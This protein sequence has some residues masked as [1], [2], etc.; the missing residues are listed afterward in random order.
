MINR[1]CTQVPVVAAEATPSLGEYRGFLAACVMSVAIA[2]TGCILWSRGAD[3][4]EAGTSGAL[5][6]SPSHALGDRGALHAVLS[7]HEW[8]AG[9]PVRARI[10]APR[11]RIW[12][13]TLDHVHV[14]DMRSLA[15]VGRFEL[16]SGSM[17]AFICPPDLVLNESGVAFVSNN[18]QPTLLEIDLATKSI[19]E[20]RLATVSSKQ[21]EIGFG[22]LLFGPDGTLFAVSAAGRTSW[23]IDV[24]AGVAHE[25]ASGTETVPDCTGQ[26]PA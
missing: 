9:E 25:I 10:D 26:D 23:R 13:L 21:W 20:H 2:A 3:V 6:S 16:P 11:Q 5:T 24:T 12:L 7:A 22:R 18:V 15:R 19:R 1:I 8:G 17:A 4:R 14:Y